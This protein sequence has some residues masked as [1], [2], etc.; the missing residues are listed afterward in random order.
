[1]SFSPEQRSRSWPF[2]L[3]YLFSDGN[4]ES[5]IVHLLQLDRNPENGEMGTPPLVGDVTKIDPSSW[6]QGREPSSKLNLISWLIDGCL[7]YNPPG[8][9]SQ[10]TQSPQACPKSA[11]GGLASGHDQINPSEYQTFDGFFNN[12][13]RVDLGAVGI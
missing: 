8:V 2:D 10:E 5:S 7:F 11:E 13:L 3:S 12:L 9:K 1:M 6:I 4:H